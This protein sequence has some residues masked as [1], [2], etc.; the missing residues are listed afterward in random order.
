[1]YGGP[2]PENYHHKAR[3]RRCGGQ[4]V[5]EIVHTI[6]EPGDRPTASTPGPSPTAP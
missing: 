4:H 1:V 5:L 3:C 6:V 2:K